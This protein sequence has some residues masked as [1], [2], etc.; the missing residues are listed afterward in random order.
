MYGG[1][2]PILDGQQRLTSLTRVLKLDKTRR[3]TR[4]ESVSEDDEDDE[5]ENST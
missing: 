3:H 5:R 4:T 1:A 2:G